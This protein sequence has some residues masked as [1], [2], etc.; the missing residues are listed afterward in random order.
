MGLS[1]YF[2]QQEVEQ[3]HNFRAQQKQ[4]MNYLNILFGGDMQQQDCIQMA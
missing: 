4:L 2:M 1:M 3:K